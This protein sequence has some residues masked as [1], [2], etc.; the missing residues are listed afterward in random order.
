M[1]QGPIGC[2]TFRTPH[3]LYTWA[4]FLKKNLVYA[5]KILRLEKN[6]NIHS[7]WS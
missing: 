6:D 4:E 1:L 7:F 2:T 5:E 3:D